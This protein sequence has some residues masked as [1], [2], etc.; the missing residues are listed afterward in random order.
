MSKIIELQTLV[1]DDD[2][3]DV[4]VIEEDLRNFMHKHDGNT[5]VLKIKSVNNS[6]DAINE[7]CYG[8]YDLAILDYKMPGKDGL[9][10]AKCIRDKKPFLPI[11]I[12]STYDIEP[13]KLLDAGI[14]AYDSKYN[15]GLAHDYK[16]TFIVS[17]DSDKMSEK[18]KDIK[19]L[20]SS[21]FN[22]IISYHEHKILEQKNTELRGVINDLRM[23]V[24]NIN[25]KLNIGLMCMGLSLKYKYDHITPDITQKIENTYDALFQINESVK[26]IQ[27]LIS[28]DMQSH[29]SH[30]DISIE[31]IVW[32]IVNIY[33]NI[34]I[35]VDKNT[36]IPLIY[37]NSIQIYESLQNILINSIEAEATKVRIKLIPEEKNVI[38]VIDDNGRGISQQMLDKIFEPDFSTKS[39]NRGLG[40]FSVIMTMNQHN[41]SL[42]VISKTEDSGAYKLKASSYENFKVIKY[43]EKKGT[44]TV[45]KLIFPQKLSKLY[46]GI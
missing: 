28:E 33:K 37:G 18:N 36:D 19:W 43:D 1:A 16:N 2:F 22:K 42:E 45:I 17:Y 13:E 32:D 15:L 12:V 21:I 39:I 3:M 25:N 40:L 6:Y 20:I 14:S 11:V 44:G 34:D 31:S 9:E 4:E 24:H 35:E 46:S 8:E 10:I 29:K 30:S 41:G 5:Y 38:L 23:H 26:E 7:L 27:G